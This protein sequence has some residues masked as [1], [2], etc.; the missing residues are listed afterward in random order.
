MNNSG[1]AERKRPQVD[2]IKNEPSRPCRGN[3]FWGKD[4]TISNRDVAPGASSP[5]VYTIHLCYT[6][7]T[8]M[9]LPM[10]HHVHT[11]VYTYSTP[12][13][14]LC[15]TYVTL[16]STYVKSCSPMLHHVHTYVYTYVI[17]CSYLCFTPILHHVHTYVYTYVTPC[18]HL[19]FHLS[20]TLSNL[21]C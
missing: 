13:P 8:P 7:F 19:C 20:Y 1:S 17:P 5:Y 9:F 12:C 11:Y 2:S 3:R 6:M 15:F 14:H 4:Q 10:L 16:C 18:S 21:I